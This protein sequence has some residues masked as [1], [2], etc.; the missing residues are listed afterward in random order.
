MHIP[1]STGRKN[2]RFFCISEYIK[3]TS[4]SLSNAE[5]AFLLVIA[6]GMSTSIGAAVV[7]SNT[8]IKITSKKMLAASLGL[9][10]GV[11]LYVSFIEIFFKS[12]SSFE[13]AGHSEK[14]AYVYATLS[15][16]GGIVSMKLIDKLVHFLDPSHL[17]H[18]DV[19]FD[20][21]ENIKNRNENEEN[22]GT[23][24]EVDPNS[25]ND[26]CETKMME[27]STQK[28]SEV[29]KGKAQQA[30]MPKAHNR[31]QEEGY[32]ESERVAEGPVETESERAKSIDAKLSL[33]K[34]VIDAKLHRMGLLTALAI[35][36]HNFPEGLATFVAALD[37]PSVGASLA[38]AIAIHNIPEGLCVSVPIY[39]ASNNRHK[40]FM[41][42]VLSGMSEIVGAGL[43]WL[44]LKDVFDE[45]IY[46]LLFGI[47]SGMMIYIC[48]FQL[49]PSAHRYDPA[50]GFVSNGVIGGMAVMAISLVAFKY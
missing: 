22:A 2:I 43:G 3:F 13:N 35:A 28:E 17:N 4:M 38:V 15:L 32:G 31:R 29:K 49:L 26:G 8:L 19:D 16:F 42:G 45:N 9:S 44:I 50:D 46:A 21:L 39:F 27:L 40:A 23:A 36:I 24:Q 7:Y 47:V 18:D 25:L 12:V 11:M 37:E 41:W 5:L 20:M 34:K 48:V 33:K 30:G 10:A 1:T 14:N 6:A